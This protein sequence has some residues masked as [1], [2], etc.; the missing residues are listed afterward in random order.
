MRGCYFPKKPKECRNLRPGAA[1]KAAV[2]AED[3]LSTG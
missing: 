1:L 2:R 3:R